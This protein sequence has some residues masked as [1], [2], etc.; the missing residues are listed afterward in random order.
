[1][2]LPPFVKIYQDGKSHPLDS[3]EKKFYFSRLDAQALDS[4]KN[5]D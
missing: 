5:Y 3:E 2:L 4:L 1:M